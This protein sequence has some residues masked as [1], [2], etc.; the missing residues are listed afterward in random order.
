MKFDSNKMI[1][2]ES[3]AGKKALIIGLIGLAAVVMGAFVDR[4]RFFHAYMLAVLFWVSIGLGGLFFTMLHHITG[5]T[6]SVVVRRLSENMMATIP[7]GAILFIPILFGMHDLYH[8]SHPELVAADKM[9]QMKSA[10]LNVT[11]FSIRTAIYFTVWILLG[12][13]LY[14]ASRKQDIEPEKDHLTRMRNLSGGGMVLFA[15]TI[16]FAGFDW[17]MSLNPH[18]YSTIFGAYFFAGSLV[19]V[20][21]MLTFVAIYLNRKGV[22][23]D[24]ITLEHYHDLGK[25]MFGFT[26][27]WGYIGGSQYF[28]IWYANLPEETVWYLDRWQGSWQYVTLLIVF[29]HFALPFITLIFQQVKRNLTIMRLVAGWIL[30]MHAVDLYWLIL[31]TYYGAKHGAHFSWMDPVAIIGV[32]GIFIWYFFRKLLSAPVIPVGDPYLEE[33]IN[34]KNA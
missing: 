34:F 11:F 19:S 3:S 15:L 1:I 29:G 30:L 20:L 18:W 10:F 33:S 8:W 5:A 12:R 6:W 31:P 32:G 27:F 7:I 21:A 9:L 4:E 24:K 14:N 28:I 26:V 23:G 17:L 13:A 22:L 16:T 2:T 25:L